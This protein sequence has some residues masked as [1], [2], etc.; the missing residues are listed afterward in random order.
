MKKMALA[1]LGAASLLLCSQTFAVS[2]PFYDYEFNQD[3]MLVRNSKVMIVSSFDNTDHITCYD[4]YGNRLW[5]TE[6]QSKIISWRQIEDIILVFSKARNSNSTYL[7]CIDSSHGGLIWK[8]P[9]Q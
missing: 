4:I 8:R 1:F 7:I 2:E 6:F 9:P 5:D 3:R